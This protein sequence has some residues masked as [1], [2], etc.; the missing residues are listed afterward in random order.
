[1]KRNASRYIDHYVE[2]RPSPLHGYGLFAKRTITAGQIWWKASLRN[3]LLLNQ[4]Q[5]ET[6]MNSH[7][8]KTMEGLFTMASVYGYYSA[9]LDSI[10]ICLD[11]ARYVNHSE[12]PNSGAP[13]NRNPLCSM[14]LRNI[15]SG[16][17]ILE[18]YLDYDPCPWSSLTCSHEEFINS[19]GSEAIGLNAAAFAN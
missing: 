1:M 15:E 14:A 8:N 6:L 4:P 19:E 16:E 3:V 13:L 18:N 2:L 5:Y 10:I 11:N 12:C 9:K 17:E 7:C